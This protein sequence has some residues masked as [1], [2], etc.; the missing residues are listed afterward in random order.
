M[1]GAKESGPVSSENCSSS[2][3]YPCCKMYQKWRLTR[4]GSLDRKAQVNLRN[5]LR[6]DT[7]K[8]DTAVDVSDAH[9][10]SELRLG[11]YNGTS[12]LDRRSRP[13]R[14]PPAHSPGPGYIARISARHAS[15]KRGCHAARAETAGESAGRPRGRVPDPGRL[16]APGRLPAPGAPP[17]PTQRGR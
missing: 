15:Q 14:P 6:S 12:L 4:S 1:P 11:E 7:P 10:S 2:C 9:N 5:L 8:K 13:G 16:S 17:R 3:I